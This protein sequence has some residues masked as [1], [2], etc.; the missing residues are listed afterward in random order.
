MEIF[1]AAAF[2]RITFRL[3]FVLGKINELPPDAEGGDLAVQYIPIVTTIR[4]DCEKI[5]LRVSMRCVDDFI[6]LA[7]GMTLSALTR[8]L[9]E[10]DNTIRREM[11]VCMF[12]HMP[13]SQAKFY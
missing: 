6:A 2:Q 3:T 4:K 8:S 7:E 11:E 10:L 5:D 12:F 13:Q 1:S 9:R